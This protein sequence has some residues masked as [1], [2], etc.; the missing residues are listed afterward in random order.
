MI[1]VI[2]NTY[3]GPLLLQGKDI[4]VMAERDN[5]DACNGRSKGRS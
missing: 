3:N 5:F 2:G 4:S 1:M